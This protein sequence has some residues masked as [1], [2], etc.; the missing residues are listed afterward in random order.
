M[1]NSSGNFLKIL[2]KKVLARVLAGHFLILII[3]TRLGSFVNEYSG[4]FIAWLTSILVLIMCYDV[5]MRYIFK[6]TSVWI[7][8]LEWH[9][10]ALIY[11][12]GAAYTLKHDAHVR[13]DV[14]YA[15]FSPKT[16][17]IIN[18]LGWAYPRSEAMVA[19]AATLPRP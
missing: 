18:F 9:L 16:Q 3:L 12:I 10:F 19:E 4:R 14:F 17:A 5:F 8:E 6:N 7:V 15:K 1:S 11:L 2:W 13:V